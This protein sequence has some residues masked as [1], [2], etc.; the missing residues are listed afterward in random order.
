M[1]TSHLIINTT[2]CIIFML[3]F[4]LTGT[5]GTGL[6]IGNLASLVTK[7]KMVD[8]TGTV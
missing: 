1:G 7:L 8:G 2:L 4:S 5:H 6:T 3:M